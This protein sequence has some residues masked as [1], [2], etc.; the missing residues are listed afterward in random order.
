MTVTPQTNTTLE[1]IADVV[2]AHESFVLCGHVSPDGD[3]LGSQLA[4][5][6]AL[7]AMGKQATCLFATDDPIPASLSFLP[8]IDDMVPAADFQG[9]AEVF[10]GIDVPS[11]ERM[12][13]YASGIRDA[14]PVSVTIDHH[15]YDTPMCDYVYVDPDSASASLL[16]WKLVRLLIA[17]PSVECAQCAY[18]GLMTDTGCFQFQNTDRESFERAA[19]LVSFGA[20]PAY[21]ATCVFQNRT[22]ASVQLEAAAM[23]RLKLICDG[24]AAL[25]WITA[26]DMGRLGAVKSDAEPIIDAVRSLLGVRI[27]CVLREQA[28]VVRGS[29]RA[30]DKTDV[31]ALAREFGG[32]GHKAAAGFTLHMPIEDAVALLEEKLAALASAR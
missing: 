12:G 14:C 6:H 23:E 7:R 9:S 10:M 19:E 11:R 3:C 27:A 18:V 21:A 29:L 5:A 13:Q 26:E 16:A 1:A 24:Q 31:S 4:I 8:G 15:A 25:S 2:R 28:G 17:E 30:K 22:H 20:D 32:G